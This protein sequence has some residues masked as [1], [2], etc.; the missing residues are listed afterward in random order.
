M[1]LPPPTPGLDDLATTHPHLALEWADSRDISTV[2]RT[3][4]YPAT[5]RCVSGK[6]EWV[7]EVRNRTQPK[8][9]NAC[10]FCQG[11]RTYPQQSELEV[12]HPKLVSEWADP[13]HS[14]SEFTPGSH[15]RALWQCPQG[16]QWRAQIYSRARAVD[17]RSC[18]R[19]LPQAQ[20]S[21]GELELLAYV[22]SVLPTEMIVETSVRYIISP[23]ELDIYIPELSLA[24]EY[25]GTYWHSLKP[26]GYHEKKVTDCRALGITLIHV[27]EAE[28][29]HEGST[30]RES[31]RKEIESKMSLVESRD[32]L[33]SSGRTY[34]WRP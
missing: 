22:E 11:V 7:S 17:A 25:N 33:R 19:C 14:L 8:R 26:E 18:P 23:R 9:P 30:T 5:W 21:S 15:Y 27:A 24:F 2:R 31:V 28:W 20:V 6:H 32:Q 10:P 12:T 16:H 13:R 1:A 4:K 29:Q 3:S 34:L